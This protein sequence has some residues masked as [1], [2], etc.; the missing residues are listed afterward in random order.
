MSD[1]LTPER[2]EALRVWCYNLQHTRCYTDADTLRLIV[3]YMLHLHDL[4]ERLRNLQQQDITEEQRAEWLGTPWLFS[5]RSQM[6]CDMIAAAVR[7]IVNS[8]DKSA[9]IE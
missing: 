1:K 9:T 5:D 4:V 7:V 8:L 2:I 6:H 3:R